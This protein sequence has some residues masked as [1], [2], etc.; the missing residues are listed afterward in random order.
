MGLDSASALFF[1]SPLFN[2]GVGPEIAIA[3]LGWAVSEGVIVGTRESFGSVSSDWLHP[4]AEI[5]S[6]N[7]RIAATFSQGSAFHPLGPQQVEN[8]VR[9]SCV[10]VCHASLGRPGE[11]C[12]RYICAFRADPFPDLL[13]TPATPGQ[14]FV[15]VD[16]ALV[17]LTFRFGV[18]PR[19]R[20][21][22][23]V[24]IHPV[25]VSRFFARS[26]PARMA[27]YGSKG[28]RS[29]SRDVPRV[30]ESYC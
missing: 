7:N 2:C 30:G 3:T 27:R 13:S 11:H 10:V 18:L 29:C 21:G 20:T 23:P 16:I 8:R 12:V 1:R 4:V 6:R 28:L 22:E 14:S 5:P 17:L 26:L 19:L 9:R 24:L 15:G 25:R